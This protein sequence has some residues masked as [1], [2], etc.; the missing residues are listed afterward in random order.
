M[1]LLYL[2]NRK[3]AIRSQILIYDLNIYE[4]L[5]HKHC[6]D[7]S[8]YVLITYEILHESQYRQ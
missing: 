7:F 8:M 4:F 6:N 1:D 3:F 5:I 2:K